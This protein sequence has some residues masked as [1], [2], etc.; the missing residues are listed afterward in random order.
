MAHKEEFLDSK[1]K[2]SQASVWQ[3]I[4]KQF[5]LIESKILT[6]YLSQINL[7]YKYID[8]F[9]SFAKIKD[10]RICLT[11]LMKSGLKWGMEADLDRCLKQYKETRKFTLY[12]IDYQ[13]PES[14]NCPHGDSFKDVYLVFVAE[15]ELIIKN[16]L[17]KFQKLKVFI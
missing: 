11:A 5:N 13:F 15:D 14:Y 3:D 10:Q 8:D 1:R 2:E 4:N 16:L 6:E 17:I 12:Y 9:I 7:T